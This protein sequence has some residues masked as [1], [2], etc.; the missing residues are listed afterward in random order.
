[1]GVA[2]YLAGY[3][4]RVS[5]GLAFYGDEDFFFQDQGI[6]Q[7]GQNFKYEESWGEKSGKFVYFAPNC[8][9]VAGILSILSD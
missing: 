5:K 6:S 4:L 2:N 7:N 8:S 1:M 3:G 9:A